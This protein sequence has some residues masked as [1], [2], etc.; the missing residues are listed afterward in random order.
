MFNQ[1]RAKHFGWHHR[2]RPTHVTHR[3][4]DYGVDISV[5]AQL[6]GES[7]RSWA[8]FYPSQSVSDMIASARPYTAQH[9]HPD[10][11]KTCIKMNND[12]AI[13]FVVNM[14]INTNFLSNR[15]VCSY[16][17]RF[18]EESIV[19]RKPNGERGPFDD[20]VFSHVSIKQTWKNGFKIELCY[21][22]LG[23]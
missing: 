18:L 19:N 4:P 15:K 8:R 9:Q 7:Y 10:G 13:I 11:E 20:A 2:R 6:P 5:C 3:N 12:T 14:H 23:S 16:Y 17:I 1:K 22:F 21:V